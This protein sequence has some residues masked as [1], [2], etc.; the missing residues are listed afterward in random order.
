VYNIRDIKSKGIVM[1]LLLL[2]W[3][4][5]GTL[6]GDFLQGG[7]G[8]ELWRI[9]CGDNFL[10][11]IRIADME[12]NFTFE[13]VTSSRYIVKPRNQQ[14][15]FTPQ[16]QTVTFSGTAITGVNFISSKID[17]IYEPAQREITVNN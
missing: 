10:E 12:R 3:L 15:L 14:I 7:M 13:N 5:S 8:V 2:A 9:Q 16:E 17:F 6:N 11:Q 1:K 4:I